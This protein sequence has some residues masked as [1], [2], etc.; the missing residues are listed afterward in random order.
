MRFKV[1][2]TVTEENCLLGHYVVWWKFTNY[3]STWRQG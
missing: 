3:C 2:P 1:L